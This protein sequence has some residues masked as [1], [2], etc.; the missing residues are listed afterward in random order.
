MSPVPRSLII[1]FASKPWHYSF[2]LPSINHLNQFNIK[3]SFVE[4]NG[5]TIGLF[6]SS[7]VTKNFH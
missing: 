2:L 3:G 6:H 4:F 1:T 5:R 7:K